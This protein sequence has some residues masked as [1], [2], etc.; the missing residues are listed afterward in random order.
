M[1]GGS[2]RSRDAQ[3]ADGPLG[4]LQAS[5]KGGVGGS[6]RSHDPAYRR[7]ERLPHA[8]SMKGGSQRSRDL[9]AGAALTHGWLPQ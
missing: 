9:L 7:G 2:L 3:H 4:D 8:A 6:Q 1:K 5:M